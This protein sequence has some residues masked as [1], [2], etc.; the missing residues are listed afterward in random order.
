MGQNAGMEK[1]QHL[2]VYAAALVRTAA[3]LGVAEGNLLEG[4]G[5]ELADLLGPEVRIDDDVMYA[6]SRRALAL[7]KEPALGFHLGR[8]ST[9]TAHG[10]VGI[11]A[12]TARTL[13]DAFAIVT[14]FFE[15]RSGHFDL[16]YEHDHELCAIELVP[17]ARIDGI[18]SLVFESLFASLGGIL[19]LLLDRPLRCSIEL[20]YSEPKHFRGYAHLFPG[21]ARF[22]RPRS[23]ALFPAHQLALP[24]RLADDFA[25]R[26]AIARCEAELASLRATSSFLGSVRR[27][28]KNRDRGF[29]SL[30]ELADAYG[31]S[32][33]TMKRRIEAH[34]TSFQT[35]LDELRRDRALFLLERDASSVESVAAE[36]GYADTANFRR[37]FKRWMG[38]TPSEWRES[39]K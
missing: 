30:T 6:L 26:E 27:Q 1:R 37:A 7:T 23:R 25:S 36:L 33:R 10:S 8:A 20:A 13:G 2:G 24:I 19:E 11:A 5:L 9:I 39:V 31:V 14:R 34:G 4:T 32:V 35:L 28:V 22:D 15:L 38:Q 16:R 18:E 17:A 29:L 3:R 12:M 21:P